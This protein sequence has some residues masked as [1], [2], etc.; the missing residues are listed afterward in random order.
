MSEKQKAAK[1]FETAINEENKK[2]IEQI[3][4]STDTS[5]I[6]DTNNSVESLNIM[7]GDDSTAFILNLLNSSGQDWI[8]G[9]Q[10]ISDQTKKYLNYLYAKYSK[11]FYGVVDSDRTSHP[12]SYRSMALQDVQYDLVR[13][14]FYIKLKIQKVNGDSVLLDDT[15]NNWLKTAETIVDCISRDLTDIIKLNTKLNIDKKLLDRITNKVGNLNK[16]L[17]EE[18]V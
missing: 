4:D 3:L 10:D 5:S 18:K 14:Q 17:F 9:I 7:I 6:L 13:K 16:K 2:I 12:D 1:A 15:L 11:R 8:K